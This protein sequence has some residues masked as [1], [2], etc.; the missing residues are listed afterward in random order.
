MIGKKNLKI[1]LHRVREQFKGKN[2]KKKMKNNNL[3]LE[4]FLLEYHV[5]INVQR[6]KHGKT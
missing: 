4:R 5:T 1:T 2:V 3:K 6:G